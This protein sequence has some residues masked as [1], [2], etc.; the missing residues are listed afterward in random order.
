MHHLLLDV[1]I[2]LW[3]TEYME[4][5]VQPTISQPVTPPQIP[6][7]SRKHLLITVVIVVIVAILASFGTY[8]VMSSQKNKQLQASNPQ[9]TSTNQLSP[10]EAQVTPTIPV[11]LATP[12]T[13]I[14]RP[15]S[16]AT[17]SWKTHTSPKFSFKYPSNLYVQEPD[18]DF[19][20]LTKGANTPT[21]LAEFSIDTRLSNSYTNYT[22]AVEKT[23]EGL[24]N[25][26]TETLPNGVK[27]K[28]KVGPG[29]GEGT[30][31][32]I[33]LLKYNQGAIAIETSTNPL[34]EDLFNQIL[35]TV[36][37]K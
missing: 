36:I 22:T 23:K 19:F 12:T 26:T 21:N 8:M 33:A 6:P 35:S 20:V 14:A 16:D 1:E 31:I 3:N 34:Q 10:I 24:T 27:I 15:T 32:V 13:P 5:T 29:Y 2:A 25:V 11:A 9:D 30:S 17:A 37:L 4:E 28:G 7:P 18:K